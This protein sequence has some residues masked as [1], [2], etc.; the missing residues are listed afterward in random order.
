MLVGA[1]IAPMAFAWHEQPPACDNGTG[2]CISNEDNYAVPR[3]VNCCADSNWSGDVYPNTA[4]SINDT[5]S[6][7]KNGFTSLDI[8][9]YK[10]SGQTGDVFCLDSGDVI[11]DLG[12]GLFSWDDVLSSNSNVTGGCN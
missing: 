8:L 5:A 1:L 3:A 2:V 12:F 11:N 6:S 7:V 4:I 9:F 10:N